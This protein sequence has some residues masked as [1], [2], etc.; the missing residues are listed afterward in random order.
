MYD[1]TRE[2]DFRLRERLPGIARGR[3][4]PGESL[5]SVFEPFVQVD[6]KRV[7]SEPQGVG[8]GLA[9]SRELA[10]AMS[11]DIG[12]TSTF[13]EGSTFTLTLPKA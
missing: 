10:V 1:D 3:G 12:A 13:G 2:S 4:I 8:L 9:I 5:E 6:A 7:S 11:G